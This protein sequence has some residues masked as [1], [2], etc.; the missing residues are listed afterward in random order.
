MKPP[1]APGQ[2]RGFTPDNGQRALYV[3]CVTPVQIEEKD[4][5]L[6]SVVDVIGGQRGTEAV[7]RYS[8]EIMLNTIHE[9]D[10]DLLPIFTQVIL[11]LRNITFFPR[12]SEIIGNPADDLSRI[13]A[14]VTPRAAE[15]GDSR[16]GHL[17]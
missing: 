8:P 1:L 16:R 15:Q 11:R 3:G 6:M 5:L 2:N 10:G 12:N 14:Q 7:F 9:S 13:I 17:A 4:N